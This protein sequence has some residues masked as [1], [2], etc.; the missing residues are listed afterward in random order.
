MGKQFI[1]HEKSE[2]NSRQMEL[3]SFLNKVSSS[4]GAAT[5]VV[6]YGP[7]KIKDELKKVIVSSNTNVSVE[8]LPS[9]HL[10]TN[11]IVA[12]VAQYFSI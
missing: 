6:L 11:Q 4:M 3:A 12:L 8:T 5:K 7:G 1:S 10:T 2:E 9:D